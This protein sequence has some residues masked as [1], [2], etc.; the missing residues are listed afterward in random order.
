MYSFSWS[1]MDEIWIKCLHIHRSL[2]QYH[3]TYLYIIW[4]TI[5]QTQITTTLLSQLT[6]TNDVFTTSALGNSSDHTKREWAT[7]CEII[8]NT[9]RQ[10]QQQRSSDIHT[11]RRKTYTCTQHL[12]TQLISSVQCS[13]IRPPPG[14]TAERRT[15][16]CWCLKSF[17]CQ[18]V[19]PPL[20]A[21]LA[22]ST[23]QW[24]LSSHDLDLCWS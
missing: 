13:S 5:L 12:K 14:W 21:A 23:W 16:R 19:H 3:H 8:L 4:S 11:T 15:S 2:H 18:S 20:A 6:Y 7:Q 9:C 10:Q 24:P 1:F 22:Q 17:P